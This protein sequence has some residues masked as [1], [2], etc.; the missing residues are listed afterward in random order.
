MRPTP[1]LS[2]FLCVWVSIFSYPKLIL[3]NHGASFS[4]VCWEDFCDTYGVALSSVPIA[5]PDQLGACEKQSHLLKLG[6]QA[7]RRYLPE[8]WSNSTVLAISCAPRN[9]TPLYRGGLAPLFM[10]TGR[11]AEIASLKPCETK[12]VGDREFFLIR[13]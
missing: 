5:A 2:A 4:G 13:Q 8:S 9:I 11:V 12:D 1:N 3:T 10:T 6:F 7:V